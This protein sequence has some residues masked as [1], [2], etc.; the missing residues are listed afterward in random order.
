MTLAPMFE[1][2]GGLHIVSIT[3]T[4]QAGEKCA[5]ME[6][7]SDTMSLTAR[8]DLAVFICSR[9]NSFEGGQLKFDMDGGRMILALALAQAQAVGW[10]RTAVPG[11]GVHMVRDG[12]EEL[13]LRLGPTGGV[14]IRYKAKFRHRWRGYHGEVAPE[15]VG[16][17][18]NR[19]ATSQPWHT[20]EER[21]EAYRRRRAA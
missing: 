18:V 17:L 11:D 9:F 20:K 13:T 1:N 19:E 14:T 4:N 5:R 21:E 6:I 15:C 7:R 12:E 10:N 8:K 16:A 3:A 2:Q